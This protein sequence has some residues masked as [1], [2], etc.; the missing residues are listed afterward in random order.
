MSERT[1][2]WWRNVASDVFRPDFVAEV[3]K[4]ISSENN[5]DYVEKVLAI[6]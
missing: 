3:E 1:R 4:I 5:L 2:A 6:E